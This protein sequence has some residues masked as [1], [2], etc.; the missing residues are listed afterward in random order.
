MICININTYSLLEIIGSNLETIGRTIYTSRNNFKDFRLQ[1]GA[2]MMRITARGG[3][4]E[5][6]SKGRT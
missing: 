1:Q 3:H 4:D 5:D 2:D 6:Y